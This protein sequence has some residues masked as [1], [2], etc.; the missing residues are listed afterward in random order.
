MRKGIIVNLKRVRIYDFLKLNHIFLIMCVIFIAGIAIGAVL[1]PD[2][3]NISNLSET[4][5]NSYITY[6]SNTSFI[7]KLFYSFFRCLTV[8]VCQYLS[9]TSMLGV[10]V[11]PFLIFCQGICFGNISAYLYCTYSLSGIAF[12]AVIL[13]PATIIFVICSFFAA[14]EAIKF[15]LTIA[16][17]TLPKSKPCNLYF[18]F[19]DYSLK[20]LL[21]SAVS[22]M[23]ALL[24]TMLSSFFLKFFSF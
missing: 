13:V 15:S 9:G 2:K 10:A 18:E 8:L 7:K 22:L 24:D 3:K 14:R 17:L 21:F 5:F 20:F 12:N 23:S 1:Y 19:K 4:L 11:V 16:R 6:H